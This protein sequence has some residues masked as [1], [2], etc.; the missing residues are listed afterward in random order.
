MVLIYTTINNYTITKLRFDIVDLTLC[1][2]Y[3]SV[4]A[5][6]RVDGV[7]LLRISILKTLLFVMK[8]T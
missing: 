6:V 2:V 4:S 7:G 1:V 5:F 3:C 8:I